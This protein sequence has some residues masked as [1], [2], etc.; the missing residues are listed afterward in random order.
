MAT[1]YSKEKY[2][3]IR[4]MKNQTLS[5]LAADSKKQKLGDEKGEIAILSSIQIALTSPSP[6]K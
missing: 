3:R 5:N 6:W 4:G 1:R 2:A